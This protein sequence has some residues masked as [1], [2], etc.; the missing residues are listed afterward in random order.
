MKKTKRNSAAEESRFLTIP[1]DTTLAVGIESVDVYVNTLNAGDFKGRKF[2]KYKLKL[3][4]LEPGQYKDKNVTVQISAQTERR[5]DGGGTTMVDNYGNSKKY[6]ELLRAIDPSVTDDD[7]P[8]PESDDEA[9]SWG[10]SWAGNIINITFGTYSFIPEGKT[11][12][13]RVTINQMKD[14]FALSVDQAESLKST[15][16]LFIAE[17]AAKKGGG[18]ADAFDP[19]DLI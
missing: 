9:K 1:K 6:V 11:E 2:D 13:D 15:A 19:D 5:V 17:M 8:M 10:Q 3:R 14:A 18:G 4:V 7:V 16:A 12:D